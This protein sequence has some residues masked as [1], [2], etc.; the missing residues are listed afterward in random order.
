MQ[1]PGDRGTSSPAQPLA[2][3]TTLPPTRVRT[4]TEHHEHHSDSTSSQQCFSRLSVPAGQTEDE[5]IAPFRTAHLRRG[6]RRVFFSGHFS[7][8]LLHQRQQFGVRLLGLPVLDP[9]FFFFFRIFRGIS[10]PV[11]FAKIGQPRAGPAGGGHFARPVRR[12][13]RRRIWRPLREVRG[14]GGLC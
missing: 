7:N 6:W 10:F 9:E 4:S 12:H 13:G 3:S 5:S 2:S 14:Y 8:R 1:L 11:E